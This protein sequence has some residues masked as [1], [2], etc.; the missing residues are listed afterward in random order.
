M[1]RTRNQATAQGA[2]SGHGARAVSA[3]L[4]GDWTIAEE[5][6]RAAL[7]QEPRDA[8]LLCNYGALLLDARQDR[9]GL[10]S[11]AAATRHGGAIHPI[12]KQSA[13]CGPP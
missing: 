5:A 4:R 1:R 8:A 9:R 2:M 13:R 6:Y 10:L 12:I 11:H 7:V 3:H